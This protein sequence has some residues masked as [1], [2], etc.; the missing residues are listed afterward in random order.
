MIDFSNPIRFRGRHAAYA[1]YL[2][3]ERGKARE[4]GA[5]VFDRIMDVYLAAVIV[6]LK[7]NR[8]A[9]A[10]DEVIM[11]SEIFGKTAENEG[12]KITSSDIN[13]ETVHSE[14]RLLNYLYR[15]VMLCENVRGLSDEEKIANAFKSEG[16]QKKIV[17]NIE[18]MNQF[19][20]GGVEILYQRFQ[21]LANDR[22]ELLEAQKELFDELGGYKE[23]LLE[24]TED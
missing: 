14:Q 19:A 17:D 9:V 13:A 16:N 22:L 11:A 6:G 8:T 7:N 4:G 2:A 10:N 24:S 21:G 3:T 1:Q 18:L 23:K 15:L 5:N 20:R 12:K